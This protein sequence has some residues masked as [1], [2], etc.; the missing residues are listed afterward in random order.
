LNLLKNI[1]VNEILQEIREKPMIVEDKLETVVCCIVNSHKASMPED[2]MKRQ[3]AL[4]I[5]KKV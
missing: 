5:P 4:K 2:S 1:I 3:G